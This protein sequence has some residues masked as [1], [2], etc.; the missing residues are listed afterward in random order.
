MFVGRLHQRHPVLP[1]HEAGHT[2]EHELRHLRSWVCRT[3]QPRLVVDRGE[4]V[5]HCPEELLTVCPA[6]NPVLSRRKYTGPR[7]KDIIDMLP[8]DDPDDMNY[9]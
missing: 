5:R 1:H 9:P 6:A 4:E 2:Y 7:T 8:T 3:L